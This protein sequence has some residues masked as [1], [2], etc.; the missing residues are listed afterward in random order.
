ML[1]RLGIF[2][3]WLFNAVAAVCAF[4]AGFVVFNQQ[5]ALSNNQ[6]FMVTG[7]LVIAAGVWLL[8]RGIRFVFV[9]PKLGSVQEPAESSPL[10]PSRN[11]API[12]PSQHHRESRQELSSPVPEPLLPPLASRHAPLKPSGLQTQEQQLP[13]SSL[14]DELKSGLIVALIIS[15][16]YVSKIDGSW[17]A[18]LWLPYAAAWI[19]G[20]YVMVTGAISAVRAKRARLRDP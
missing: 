12:P 7:L 10:A 5:G 1:V 15:T 20:V 13:A 14:L 18:W 6:T 9:G 3:G 16:Q 4:M 11:E 2:L 8:G 19:L 17:W